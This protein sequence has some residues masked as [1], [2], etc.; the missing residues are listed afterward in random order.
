MMTSM[1]ET[2]F[3]L[4]LILVMFLGIL[5][6]DEIFLSRQT[7]ITANFFSQRATLVGENPKQSKA[8]FDQT[9][10]KTMILTKPNPFYRIQHEKK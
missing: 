2:L 9:I 6:L 5:I 3:S 7:Q 4:K 10:F 8:V 1:V